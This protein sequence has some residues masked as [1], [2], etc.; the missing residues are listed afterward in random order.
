MSLKRNIRVGHVGGSRRAAQRHIFRAPRHY[1]PYGRYSLLYPFKLN[2]L[3]C[4][5]IIGFFLI[6]SISTTFFN[7]PHFSST[8]ELEEGRFVYNGGTAAPDM[9][10]SYSISTTNKSFS[11]TFFFTRADP[12]EWSSRFQLP[13]ENYQYSDNTCCLDGEFNPPSAGK[14]FY[15]IYNDPI[16]EQDTVEIEFDVKYPRGKINF[17]FLTF[18]GFIIIIIGLIIGVIIYQRKQK[19]PIPLSLTEIPTKPVYSRPAPIP[20]P[21][22][23]LPPSL[24]QTNCKQC[25][26]RLAP[27][28]RFCVE[29]GQL[30]ATQRKKREII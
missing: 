12:G 20:R 3:I 2:F 21:V 1:Q 27:G 9:L 6:A 22:P 16:L 18:I 29:C 26:G 28:D 7:P 30:L 14:W 15:V 24:T 8:I 23:I 25:R 11:I 4:I 13:E 10:I 17:A 5:L 19:R